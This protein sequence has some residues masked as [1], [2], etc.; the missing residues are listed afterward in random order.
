MN[1]AIKARDTTFHGDRLTIQTPNIALDEPSFASEDEW[2]GLGPS[3]VRDRIAGSEARS[4]WIASS[5]T[6]AHSKLV[7]GE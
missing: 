5:N 3:T 2:H 4:A 6:A 1:R 7:T